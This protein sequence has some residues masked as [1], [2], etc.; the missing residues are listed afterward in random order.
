MY[1]EKWGSFPGVSG[2]FRK[3]YGARMRPIFARIVIIGA[4]EGAVETSKNALLSSLSQLARFNANV[5]GGTVRAGCVLV[6]APYGQG[7][8]P[9]FYEF[10]PGRIGLYGTINLMDLSGAA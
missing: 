4:S 5:P 1:E 8:V 10:F 6:Q 2:M 7:W 3:R 9:E